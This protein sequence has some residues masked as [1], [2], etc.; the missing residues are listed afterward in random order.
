MSY[1]R[2]RDR[3][4]QF[5]G[6]PYIKYKSFYHEQDICSQVL[7][8]QLLRDQR[9]TGNMEEKRRRKKMRKINDMTN[10]SYS[11]AKLGRG[12]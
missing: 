9:S 10:A 3:M 11:L 7:L 5:I 12:Y 4:T 2:K 1:S 8:G 6:T